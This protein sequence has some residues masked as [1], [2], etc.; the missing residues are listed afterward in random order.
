MP[1]YQHPGDASSVFA[2]VAAH[3]GQSP[4]H[5]SIRIP[6]PAHDGDGDNC[7][8][9]LNDAGEIRAKCWSLRCDGGNVLAAIES[10]TGIDRLNPGESERQWRAAERRGATAPFVRHDGS[11][12]DCGLFSDAHHPA[13]PAMRKINQAIAQLEYAA[14]LGQWDMLCAAVVSDMGQPWFPAELPG[15][16]LGGPPDIRTH[17]LPAWAAKRL[18]AAREAV[19]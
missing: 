4:R 2:I 19:K 10:A 7:E 6:C 8:I 11:C 13:C 14:E 17:H 16:I 5:G 18:A 3:Y 12:S 15:T 1:T 9:F